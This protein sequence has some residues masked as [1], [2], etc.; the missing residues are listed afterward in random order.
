MDTAPQNPRV[1]R[2]PTYHALWRNPA[3]VYGTGV[4]WRVCCL[5]HH[6]LFHLEARELP[7]L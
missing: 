5:R 7:G 2:L 4:F 3:C 1:R 6:G